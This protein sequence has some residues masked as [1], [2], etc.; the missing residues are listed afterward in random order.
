[1]KGGLHQIRCEMK[2][3]E[4]VSVGIKSRRYRN[5]CGSET[6]LGLSFIRSDLFIAKGFWHNSSSIRSNTCHRSLLMELVE[7]YALKAINR[8]LL[9]ALSPTEQ[10]R[11][12]GES[13]SP[14]H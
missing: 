12:T 2:Q 3:Q 6:R 13:P 11:E 4:K 9:T 1:M 8:S 14:S 5:W 10:K 7:A